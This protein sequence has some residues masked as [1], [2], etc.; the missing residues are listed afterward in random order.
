MRFPDQSYLDTLS[1]D[2]HIFMLTKQ[3]HLQFVGFWFL[4]EEKKVTVQN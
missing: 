1:R 2:L 3:G 4:L